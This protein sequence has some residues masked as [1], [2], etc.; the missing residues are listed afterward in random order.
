MADTFKPN[1]ILTARGFDIFC[2]L[3][4]ADA[5]RDLLRCIAEAMAHLESRLDAIEFLGEK[6]RFYKEK[7]EK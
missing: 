3:E 7:E 2:E 1:R 4:K 5:N 6:F